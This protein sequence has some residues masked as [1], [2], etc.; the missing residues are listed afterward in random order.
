ME[1][2]HDRL[3]RRAEFRFY[4][5]L[6]DFLPVSRRQITFSH[7]FDNRPAVK[8]AIESLGVPHTEVDLIL[9]NGRPVRF[10]HRITDGDRVAVYPVFEAL[11]GSEARLR[12]RPQREPRFVLDAHL[13]RLA[14][15]MR[16]I[17]FDTLY[18]GDWRDPEIARISSGERR[19]LVT[20]D[21]ALL[22]RGEVTHGYWVRETEPE[23]QLAEVVLR[24]DLVDSMRPF[25][26][27]MR[28]NGKVV[29]VAKEAVLH[30]LE[31]KTRR[32]YHEFHRCT[33]CGQVYWQ[34]S[35]FERLRGIVDRVKGS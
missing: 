5:E 33:G 13:G 12:P 14:G 6:N 31:P 17:G 3:A 25:E 7:A 1:E 30:L 27:C 32:H 23:A 2:Q 24:F 20:R 18:R 10:G 28:C 15:Y 9:V 21:K 29:P 26:R 35:H 34:G 16:L 11:I 8:D 19:I 22:K 4:A